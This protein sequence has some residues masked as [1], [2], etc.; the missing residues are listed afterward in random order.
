MAI[1]STGIGDFVDRHDEECV[2]GV[3]KSTCRVTPG[4]GCFACSS[5]GHS[6][7]EAAAATE[8]THD[9]G[10]GNLEPFHHHETLNNHPNN[11]P[12]HP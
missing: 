2:F 8:A 3:V 6:P 12:S 11:P 9:A 10:A 4:E 5:T 7:L 1:N